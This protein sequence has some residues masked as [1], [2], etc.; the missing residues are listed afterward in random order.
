V[1]NNNPKDILM[2]VTVIKIEKKRQHFS[3]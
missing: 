1:E 3:Y 2:N